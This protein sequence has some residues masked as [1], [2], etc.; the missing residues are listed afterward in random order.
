MLTFYLCFLAGGL[1]LPVLNLI[2][3]FLS[4]DL[5]TDVDTD[6]DVDADIDIDLDGEVDLHIG[7]EMSADSDFDIG[8]DLDVN[9][10][11]DT[12]FDTDMDRIEAPTTV[13][14]N[15]DVNTGINFN[16]DQHMFS[17]S[18]LPSSLLSISALAITFGATGAV[19]TLGDV[20]WL[21]T[22]IISTIFGYIC[23]IIIQS[24]IKTL[25][26]VQTRSYG[27]N[28]NELL[29]YDGTVVD[30]ILPG[31]LGSVSFLTLKNVRVSYPAKCADANMKIE[32]GRIIKA[33]EFKN[34]IFIVE[35]K[36]KYE[37]NA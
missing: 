17:L 23:S 19:M 27:I 8:S 26:K 12:D 15:T 25:K 34:G 11:L 4:N 37:T 28:E 5:D 2:M 29:L 20:G 6:I 9:S 21:L 22:I 1:V 18:L 35:P 33:K 14:T 31:Q 36:N 3:G 7:S 16:P 10:D 32:A 30:T 13:Q 24:I